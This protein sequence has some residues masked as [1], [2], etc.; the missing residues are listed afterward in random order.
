MQIDLHTH[1]T[2][3]DGRLCPSELVVRAANAGVEV[4]ALTD[5]DGTDGLEEARHA[6]IAAGVHFI[7]GIELSVT[8]NKRTVHIVG[9]NFNPE[10]EPLKAGIRALQDFREIRAREIASKLDQAGIKGAYEGAQRFCGGKMLGRMHFANFLID[11][12]HA[13]NVRNVFKHF[14]VNNKPG[15]VT[16]DWA[17]LEDAVSWITGAGGIAVIAHPARYKLTRTKLRKLIKDFIAAGGQAIE[18]VSGSHDINETKTMANHASDFDLYASAGSDFHDPDF[19]W[20]K[21]GKMPPLPRQC[22]PVWDLFL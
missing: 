2:A 14:L 7:N 3:S 16:G 4:I 10:Y 8:W 21:L 1:S 12:G 5:H 17:T 22:R 6:A 9:L 18:V 11:A 13:K 20:I 19:P 15:H